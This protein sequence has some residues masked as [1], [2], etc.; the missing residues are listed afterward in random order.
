MNKPLFFENVIGWKS[1]GFHRGTMFKVLCGY[2]G[3]FLFVNVFHNGHVGKKGV[4]VKP[5]GVAIGPDSQIYVADVKARQVFVYDAFGMYLKTIGK[6]GDLDRPVDVAVSKDGKR[7]Y[8]V[9]AGGIDSVRHRL[10]VYDENGKQLFAVGKRGRGEGEFNLP[11]QVAVAPDGTVYV[12]DAGNFR[13]QVFSPDG[14]FLRMWGEAGRAY[15][16]L[17]RPRGLALDGNGNVY[18]TDAAYR[19]FQVFN[20]QG[21]LL[22]PI[23]GEELADKPGQFA[24]PA[25]IAVDELGHVYIVD[26]VFAKIDVIRRLSEKERN[27]IIAAR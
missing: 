6:F 13:I 4:L 18:I 23:G 5:A 22:L 26:Q 17:A 15:G 8:V 1:I 11:A 10:V 25:G 21:Q 27:K 20:P 9:D 14:R 16:D 19:N 24:L 2:I 12:L 3:N 7:V